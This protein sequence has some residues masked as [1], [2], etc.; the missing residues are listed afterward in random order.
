MYS[1]SLKRDD[2]KCSIIKEELELTSCFKALSREQSNGTTVKPRSTKKMFDPIWSRVQSPGSKVQSRVQ[3]RFYSMPIYL[4]KYLPQTIAS[5]NRLFKWLVAYGETFTAI[6][7]R[8]VEKYCKTLS[9]WIHE[10]SAQPTLRAFE[11]DWKW[12][13]MLINKRKIII[14]IGGFPHFIHERSTHPSGVILIWFVHVINWMSEKG[15][16]K[17]PACQS[18][19]LFT[20]K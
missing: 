6:I 20:Y 2:L 16:E 17:S 13:Q 1:I 18:Q 7:V 15:F 9:F 19:F 3:S 4:I 10:T 8:V 12:H 11:N 14:I 5:A